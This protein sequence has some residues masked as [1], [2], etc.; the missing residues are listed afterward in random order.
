M[1]ALPVW[2][3]STGT[4]QLARGKLARATGTGRRCGRWSSKA[5]WPV[6]RVVYCLAG[7]LN[8][9]AL[10]EAMV[11]AMDT[12]VWTR[13]PAGSAQTFDTVNPA[14]SGVIATFPAMR[15]SE[16]GA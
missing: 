6:A 15:D 16:V 4:G 3:G 13:G 8:V 5:T 1:K 12:T 11:R 14:T 2:H 7:V 10:D 9:G